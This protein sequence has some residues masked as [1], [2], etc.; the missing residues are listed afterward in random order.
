[1]TEGGKSEIQGE[2]WVRSLLT[3][4]QPPAALLF[5]DGKRAQRWASTYKGLPLLVK[6]LFFRRIVEL[7][8][9]DCSLTRVTLSDGQEA[10]NTC[11]RIESLLLLYIPNFFFLF[12]FVLFLDTSLGSYA[13]ATPIASSLRRRR[14][15]RP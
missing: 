8:S 14:D 4:K 11:R 9:T 15:A 12:S 3:L 10:K 7:D 1:M 2:A 5:M 13:H 6:A